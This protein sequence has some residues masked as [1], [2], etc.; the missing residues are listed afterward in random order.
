MLREKDLAED[1]YA[2]L[3]RRTA[4]LCARYGTA[5][6]VHRFSG[7]ARAL[8]GGR[9]QLP[10]PAFRRFRETGEDPGGLSLGVS[11]HSEE[12]ALYAASQGAAWVVAG[13]IFQTP[14]K[15]GLPP[16]GLSFLA[17][18]CKQTALPVYAIGGVCET[19][20]GAVRKA[21]AA[22]ACLMSPFMENADPAAYGER[23][24][25]AA[26]ESGPAGSVPGIYRRGSRTGGAAG[27]FLRYSQD[28]GVTSW[29]L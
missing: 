2:A 15:P 5:F 22:G 10:F 7:L 9:L 3:A 11:V 6:I 25:A 16:R 24:K 1:E 13:H 21:G 28:E 23:L 14:S 19:N 17:R 12:E 27:G 20:I 8:G 18:I 26:G 29:T 4:E